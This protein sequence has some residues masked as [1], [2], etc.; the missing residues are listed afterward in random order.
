M[1]HT[2][3]LV[4][5]LRLVHLTR[6][7]VNQEES[8]AVLPPLSGRRAVKRCAHG[9][10]KQLD[11]HLIRDDLSLLDVVA[12]HVA[13]LRSLAVLLS[14]EQVSRREVLEAKLLDNVSTLR[15]LACLS[16]ESCG[17]MSSSAPEN[18]PAP[19]PPRTKTTVTLSWSKVGLSRLKRGEAMV[20]R[21]LLRSEIQICGLL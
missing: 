3:N 20:G 9:V 1:N 16:A 14:S 12:D 21:V 19:G 18:A 5:H 10:F 6:E 7:A 15:A 4:K 2:H 13:I 11:R 17:A 8:L